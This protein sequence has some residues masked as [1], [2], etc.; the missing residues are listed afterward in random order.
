MTSKLG[1]QTMAMHIMSNISRSNGNQTMKFGNLI[2]YDKIN[3]FIQKSC[4]KW[5]RETSSK[6]LFVL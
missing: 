1:Q 4:R 6:P 2:E 3:T 5:G